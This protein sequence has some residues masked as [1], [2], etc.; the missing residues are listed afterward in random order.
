[1]KIFFNLYISLLKTIKVVRSINEKKFNKT[2]VKI[3]LFKK[4]FQGDTNLS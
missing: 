1:M 4:C 2:K 3:E